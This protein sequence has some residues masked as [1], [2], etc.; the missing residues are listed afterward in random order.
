ML[1]A[2][3]LKPTIANDHRYERALEGLVT[4]VEAGNLTADAF[5]A[6]ADFLPGV[7]G[8]YG[9]ELTYF[10][11]AVFYVATV[12]TT[13]G[14][15]NFTPQT[16]GGRLFVT[17]FAFIGIALMGFWMSEIANALVR[18]VGRV[19]TRFF[20]EV[21]R[22]VVLLSSVSARQPPANSMR[23]RQTFSGMQRRSW[24]SCRHRCPSELA[25]D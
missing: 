10:S 12:M 17:S 9:Y 11:N 6:V 21:A 14:Y 22:V 8:E 24:V 16:E 20:V 25:V 3:D 7:P 2:A 18:L 1:F 4:A 15:G 5:D 23:T 13:I 19:I